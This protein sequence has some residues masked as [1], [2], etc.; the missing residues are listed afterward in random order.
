MLLIA[1]VVPP[2]RVD[3]LFHST[4]IS[5]IHDR[6]S[7]HPSHCP[8]SPAAVS[9]LP[10]NTPLSSHLTR[11]LGSKSNR[12]A[13]MNVSNSICLGA[14]PEMNRVEHSRAVLPHSEPSNR[15][16]PAEAP[17]GLSY[18]SSQRRIQVP[19]VTA[20]SSRAKLP[21]CKKH[22]WPIAWLGRDGQPRGRGRGKGELSRNKIASLLSVP[23]DAVSQ[24]TACRWVTNSPSEMSIGSTRTDPNV[25]Q[26]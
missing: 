18:A 24:S 4:V 6:L 9:A 21:L 20:L 10:G 7:A 14:L 12:N 16:M 25:R 23:L 26:Q 13:P 19:G 1:S 2:I 11:Q 15:Q 3:D 17:N 22:L 8:F 5:R